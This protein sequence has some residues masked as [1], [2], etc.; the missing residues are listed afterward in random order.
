MEPVADTSTTITVPL[1][2]FRELESLETRLPSIMEAAVSAALEQK[3]RERLSKLVGD[4]SEHA[5]RQLEK[6]HKNRDA[7]NA[8]RRAAY[9][10]KKEAGAF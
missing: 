2:R 9:K 1:A 5:K 8:R 3:K 10:A 6:Y 4:P 7:I